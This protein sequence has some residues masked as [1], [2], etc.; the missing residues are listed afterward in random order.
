MKNYWILW[1][2][3]TIFL[4][5]SIGL[6]RKFVTTRLSGKVEIVDRIRF[7]TVKRFV[8]ASCLVF[9]V[10]LGV[11]V[12]MAM[13]IKTSPIIVEISYF[14]FCRLPFVALAALI[15][16]CALCFFYNTARKSNAKDVLEEYSW[17]KAVNRIY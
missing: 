1:A 16:R 3:F 15:Y 14:V 17:Q 5:Y 8:N 9:A 2:V 11:E 6:Y 4:A 7:K 13:L 10:I 12:F